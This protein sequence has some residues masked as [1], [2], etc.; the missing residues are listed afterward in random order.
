VDL[1]DATADLPGD[2][3]RVESRPLF[4]GSWYFHMRTQGEDESWTSTVHVGPF[5]IVQTGGRSPS[6]TPEG[7]DEP[8]QTPEPT[9]EVTDTPTPA[10]VETATPSPTP[11]KTTPSPSL[12]P[13]PSPTPPLDQD[14]DG[15]TDAIEIQY[16]SNPTNAASTPENRQFDIDVNPP[17]PTCGDGLDNDAN[18][19]TDLLDPK[20]L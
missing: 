18:G 5:V 17:I 9:A 1:P 10:P 14:A 16:G 7:T 20:C 6:P 3:D 19:F 13:S 12:S 8:T 2:A 11:V 15:W 4:P